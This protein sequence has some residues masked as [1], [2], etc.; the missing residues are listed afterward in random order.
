MPY[1]SVS[2]C[3]RCHNQIIPTVLV[4]ILNRGRRR[5][6]TQ[7]GWVH[8][9]TALGVA[10]GACILLL[11]LGTQILDWY[12]LPAVFVAALGFGFWKIW[13][14][15]PNLYQ[16]AQRI[17]RSLSLHD[18]L[19]TAFHFGTSPEPASAG[20][21]ELQSKQA[22]E[23][24][25]TV[26][27]GAALP[28]QLPRT[29]YISGVLALVALTMFGIRY[30]VTQ[31]LDFK[32][33]L[34]AMAFDNFFSGSD[35]VAKNEDKLPKQQKNLNDEF[36]KMGIHVNTADQKMEDLDPG[37]DHSTDI[38]DT[39][40]VNPEAGNDSHDKAKT[41][42]EAM[43]SEGPEEG[44]DKEGSDSGDSKGKDKEPEAGDGKSDQSKEAPD[45]Q[46]QQ[47]S[48]NSSLMDKLKDAMQN[49]LNKMKQQQKGNQQKQEQQ[50]ASKEGSSQQQQGQKGDQQGQ[51]KDQQGQQ[52][53]G[54]G[55][56]QKSEGKD[57][58][59][60]QKSEN[61][62]GKSSEQ[63]GNQQQSADAKSGQGKQDGSKD[64]KDAELE[65][66]MGKLSEIYGK[67][68]Q[69]LT[70]EITIEVSSGKQQLKTAY[71]TKTSS[72][73]ESGGEINRDEVPLI[74]Q[75]Y[76][77]KYF[78]QIRKADAAAERAKAPGGSATPAAT[79]PR[80]GSGTPTPTGASK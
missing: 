74:Y 5:V 13:Q 14:A 58:Q 1:P 31:S 27:L 3:K 50:N 18:A 42:P 41:S 8:L 17:D 55:K 29:A 71:S 36:E 63:K 33:S 38:V 22:A 2:H 37:N 6:L 15:T 51:Q 76:V 34:V 52:Q 47:K 57:G 69:N 7:L 62:Q 45:K 49:M 66:A 72:H 9:I 61:A 20:V 60:G 80:S 78:D 12:W 28:F 44:N 4:D 70:G 73:K 10:C 21:K 79:A 25:R 32:P 24:A 39:P 43:K 67:R 48:D 16:V 54:E 26:D 46:G 23:I 75:Q 53:A 56:E 11:L 19:S 35:V 65:K 77:E 64:L 40:D 68:Q 30:G 59:Q